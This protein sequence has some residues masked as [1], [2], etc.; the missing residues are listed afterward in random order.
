V[1]HRD[2][3]LENF[4][5]E[6]EGD[7]ALTLTVTRT[8]TLPL[9]LPLTPNPNPNPNPNPSTTPSTNPN[10]SANQAALK[11]IDF[12]LSAIVAKESEKMTDVVP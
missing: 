10:P 11:L 1:C 9:P 8:L 7:Q 3:K 6:R 2:I 12:G 5:F 4:V